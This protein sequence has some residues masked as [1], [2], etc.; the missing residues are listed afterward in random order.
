MSFPP[1]P[2]GT[3]AGPSSTAETPQGIPPT[4]LD[5]KALRTELL[6]RRKALTPAEWEQASDSIQHRVLALPKWQAARTVAL[7]VAARNEVSTDTLLRAAWA[8]GKQVLLPRCLPP[9]AGEGIMAF[10]PC[11]GYNQLQPGAF[12][13]LEP[14]P[15]C[16]ALPR[17]GVSAPVLPELIL[18]PAVGI[19]P[20]GARLGYG[21]GF[22]DRL[23]ALPGWNTARRLALVHAF[24]IA[25]FPAGPL[26]VAMHGYA[27]E[28]ELVWL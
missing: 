3:P 4:L 20:Q 17:E 8:E 23:L 21:K 13:L 27:T 10:V 9:S 14:T 24:Q 18:V 6:R 1:F 19:S 26:D 12:G 15:G 2:S 5:K 11:R 25:D 22:Y 16:P 28:K 7:Y